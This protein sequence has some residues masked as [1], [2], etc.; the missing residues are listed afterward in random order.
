MPI[1][2]VVTYNTMIFELMRNGLVDAAF[3]VFD[4]MPGPDKVSW[5]AL[6]DGF[7]KNGRHDEAIDCFRAM[8]LD[9]VKP[10]YV[11]LIAVVSTCAEVGSLGLGMW[12]HR[13]VLR[14]GLERAM[15]V[16]PTR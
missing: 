15:S 12:V 16:L 7:V 9:D 10:D 4:G 5:T 3:E 1:R 11:T 8:L 2:S 6:I 14:Q 13:L